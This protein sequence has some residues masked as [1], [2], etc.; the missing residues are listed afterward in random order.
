[1]LPAL[2]EFMDDYGKEHQRQITLI[3]SQCQGDP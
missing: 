2:K 1:M 3:Q